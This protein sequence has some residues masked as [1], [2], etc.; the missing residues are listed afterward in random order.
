MSNSPIA[1]SCKNWQS[2]ECPYKKEEALVDLFADR[3]MT[4]EKMINDADYICKKCKKFE[5]NN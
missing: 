4:T 2:I 3:T 1:P 5:S